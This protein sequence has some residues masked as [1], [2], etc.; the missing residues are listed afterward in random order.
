[1][2]KIFKYTAI[3]EGFSWIALIIGMIIKYG[4]DNPSAVKYPG[5]IHGWLF[6]AYIILAF[7]VKREMVWDNKTLVIVLIAS[8]VPF[9]TFYIDRKYL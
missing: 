9:G 8:I 2:Q 1:M 4:F 3:L 6:I 5:M 7:W